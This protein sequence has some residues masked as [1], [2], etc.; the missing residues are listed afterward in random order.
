MNETISFEFV[1]TDIVTLEPRVKHLG[2]M[3]SFQAKSLL[4]RAQ[5]TKG[6]PRKRLLE[7][8]RKKYEECANTQTSF[9]MVIK[10]IFFFL[11]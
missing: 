10:L 7:M 6:N 9:S 5:Q 2:L 11:C 3:Y 8:A 4:M 1:D